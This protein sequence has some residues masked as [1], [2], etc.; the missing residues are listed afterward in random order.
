MTQA[1]EFIRYDHHDG[2]VEYRAANIEELIVISKEAEKTST[3]LVLTPEQV[4]ESILYQQ[5]HEAREYLNA[6]DWYTARLS[7]TG[8]AIPAD[9]I[10]KRQQARQLLSN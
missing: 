2:S 3:P 8:K 5:K 7:E 4:A 6:T 9:V 10:A 1:T